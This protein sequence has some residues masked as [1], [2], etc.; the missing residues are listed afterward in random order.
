VEL[1]AGF[2]AE[3]KVCGLDRSVGMLGVARRRLAHAGLAGRIGLV[4]GDAVQLPYAGGCFD[5]LFMSFTLELFAAP[6]I[7]LVLAEC[8]RVLKPGG[9]LC[10]VALAK[11]DPP[12]TITRVYEWFHEKLPE[13]IDCRP[14]DVQQALRSAGFRVAEATLFSLYG[15][16]G[17]IVQAYK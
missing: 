8:R 12:N 17:E 1:A 14:I 5:G 9:R 2:G 10:I 15:L 3:G 6:E 16:S 4:C 11:R 13:Y 7:T